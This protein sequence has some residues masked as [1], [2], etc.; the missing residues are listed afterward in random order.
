[1]ACVGL[2]IDIFESPRQLDKGLRIRKRQR[3]NQRAALELLWA[4]QKNPAVNVGVAAQSFDTTDDDAV[5]ATPKTDGQAAIRAS[6]DDVRSDLT[7]P[8]QQKLLKHLCNSLRCGTK[9]RGAILT[10]RCT[11]VNHPFGAGQ[12]EEG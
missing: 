6:G 7:H 9:P 5:A 12:S 2:L 11:R 10:R 1:M 4:V 3:I 8:W